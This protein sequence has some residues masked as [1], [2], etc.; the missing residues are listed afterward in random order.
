MRYLAIDLGEKRT[1][2]AA[3]DSETRIV[4]PLTVLDVSMSVANG[5]LLLEG[6]AREAWVPSPGQHCAWCDH[7]SSCRKRSGM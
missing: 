3:G 7:L 2:L 4:S 1:G 5:Q 6:I